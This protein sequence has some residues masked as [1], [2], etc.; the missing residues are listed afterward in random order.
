MGYL[1]FT[2]RQNL[3]RQKKGS[4]VASV[5][6]TEF[7]RLA[8][9]DPPP[10]PDPRL[11][12]PRKEFASEAERAEAAAESWK[13]LKGV[14]PDLTLFG[15]LGTAA[16]L[17]DAEKYPEARSAY[18]SALNNPRIGLS[19]ELKGRALEGIALTWEAEENYPEALKAYEKLKSVKAPEFEKLVVFHI[20]RVEYLSGNKAKAIELLTKLDTELSK[21]AGPEGPQDYV[22]AAVRDLLK[23]ADP[24]RAKKEREAIQAAQQQRWM[25]QIM[26]MQKQRGQNGMPQ[27][28]SIPSPSPA[29]EAP[30]PAPSGSE[31]DSGSASESKPSETP[32]PAPSSAPA[33]PGTAPK[34][35]GPSPA[36]KPPAAPKPSTNAPKPA[37][38]APVA[39]PAAAPAVPVP[40]APAAPEQP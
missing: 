36:P 32:E 9:A 4:I 40:A 11:V 6:E 39:P 30:A 19:P 10:Q 28:P 25:E 12:D 17:Y 29:P 20:A 21:D 3:E 34:K 35:E 26:E 38:P 27:L 22:G 15:L 18:E 37:A 8:V 13:K 14:S 7:G 1:I 24:S 2:Y 23:T 16:S 5:L 33:S 31:G